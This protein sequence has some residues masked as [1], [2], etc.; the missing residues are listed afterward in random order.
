MDLPLDPA[1][2]ESEVVHETPV[3]GA[4]GSLWTQ[5][6]MARLSRTEARGV[7]AVPG[8]GEH[9]REVLR[10]AGLSEAEI[11]DLIGRETTGGYEPYAG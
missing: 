1:L 5:G 9:S 11:C 2:R 7:L 4:A 8:L 10:E 3:A 6:R